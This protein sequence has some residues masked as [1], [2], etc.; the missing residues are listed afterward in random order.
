MNNTITETW[1][2]YQRYTCTYIHLILSFFQIQYFMGKKTNKQTWWSCTKEWII[3]WKWKDI[4]IY[5]YMLW[6]NVRCLLVHSWLLYIV[7]Y[8]TTRHLIM[9]LN[10]GWLSGE[11]V[12]LWDVFCSFLGQMLWPIWPGNK[13]VAIMS[14]MINTTSFLFDII[15]VRVDFIKVLLIHCIADIV[16][17]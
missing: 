2:N 3:S 7:L 1:G 12:C 10:N 11:H 9:L 4:Y 16:I 13:L 5:I 14:K 15:I 6:Q 8:V 17:L